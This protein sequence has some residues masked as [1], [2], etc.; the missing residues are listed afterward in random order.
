[1]I[2][3]IFEV[4]PKASGKQA[5]MD[6][7]A[8]LKIHLASMPGFISIERF[9]SL[10]DPE[11]ILS[12]S[13]WEDETAVARWRKDMH[14]QNAQHQGRHHLFADYRLRVASIL[15]DYGM[16]NRQQAPQE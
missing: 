8:E 15:R 5:Y 9:Q 14:H 7:A 4:T 16:N 12:L 13:F 11:K 1:M 3:I 2:A 6:I 10:N